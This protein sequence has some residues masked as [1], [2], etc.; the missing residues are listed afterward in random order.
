MSL[1]RSLLSGKIWKLPRLTLSWIAVLLWFIFMIW[2]NHYCWATCDA[3]EN[4]S[5]FIS[6]LFVNWERLAVWKTFL[7]FM[8]LSERNASFVDYKVAFGN[9]SDCHIHL[10]FELWW[11]EK[12]FWGS[13]FQVNI[14]HYKQLLKV[15]TLRNPDHRQKEFQRLVQ[16]LWTIKLYNFD[17]LNG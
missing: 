1:I 11:W 8:L 2:F 5:L 12:F 6:F 7:H 3:I 15:F 16:L 9:F 4:Y 10:N 17:L 14:E 13:T